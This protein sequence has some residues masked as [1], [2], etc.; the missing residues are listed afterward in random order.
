MPRMRKSAKKKR[1]STR[2]DH[3]ETVIGTLQVTS[4]GYGFVVTHEG[5]FFIPRARI[6][7]GMD[8]DRVEV[9]RQSRPTHR[10][11]FPAGASENAQAPEG[12]IVRVVERAHVSLV[13]RYE[14]SG[15]FGF[16]IPDDRRIDFDVFVDPSGGL[17]AADGDVVV[18]HI[19]GYPSRHEG[20][21]GFIEEIVAHADDEHLDEAII[22]ARHGFETVFSEAAHAE[23]Q[24]ARL[25]IKR[26]L[27]ESDRRD[28]RDRLICTIDPVDARD[29]DDALSLEATENGWRLGVHI[30][31]VS[32]YVPWGSSIDLDARRRATSVYLPGRVIPMLPEEL[33]CNLCSLRPGVERLAFTVDL[34]LAPDGM[35]LESDMYPSVICSR[36][37]LDYDALQEVFDGRYDYAK[38]CADAQA[39][40]DAAIGLDPL[41]VQYALDGLH[42]VAGYLGRQRIARGA[43]DFETTEVKVDLDAEGAPTGIRLRHRN[44]ATELVEACM[45]AA[46]EAVAQHMLAHEAPCAYRVHEEPLPAALDDLAPVLHE[47][48]HIDES[49][50]VTIADVRRIARAVKGTPEEELIDALIL[51][52]M[53]RAVY[54]DHFTTHFGLASTGYTHFTSPIRR[55][56]DLLVHRL[57]RAQLRTEAR[58]VDEAPVAVGNA[59]EIPDQLPWLCEHSS[60]MERE[61]EAAAL[62][63]TKHQVCLY[64]QQFVGM[65]YDATITG[66]TGA[67]LFVR[68]NIGAEGLVR[69]ESL[70]GGLTFDA[71]RRAYVSDKG[72]LVYRLG[73]SVHVRLVEV[74]PEKSQMDFALI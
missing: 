34:Y 74:A 47:F 57:L 56:P 14:D 22:I 12:R 7:G 35:L 67:G 21:I 49:A 16:V 27:E 51:R 61:A 73:D 37:R 24:A 1:S 5:D 72:A 52:A 2:T 44:D 25:D 46:N 64:M 33:S 65:T 58:C 59:A 17:R 48:G 6:N 10:G 32:T 28:I 29:F 30:A 66:V 50:S 11:S 15:S 53:K 45:I 55:Y 18:V 8:G 69:R 41:A 40:G 71:P 38:L 43:L 9:A 36:L 26:A 3:R 42:K 20:C 13:G 63:A 60:I 54:S 19:T 23:A 62:E 4:R 39:K 31:D 70:P 68:A